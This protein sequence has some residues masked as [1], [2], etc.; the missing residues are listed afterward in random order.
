MKKPR[1]VVARGKGHDPKNQAAPSTAATTNPQEPGLRFHPLANIFPLTEGADFDD[2][3]ADFRAH[4][5]RHAIVLHEGMILDGRNRY[6]ACFAAG[7]S[8]EDMTPEERPGY[9]QKFFG[10]DPVA[11]VISANLHRRHLT[12]EQKREIIAKVI[13]ATPA[14]S[15]RAV[16]K[17]AKA[18]GKTVASVRREMEGRAEVP[19]VEKRIDAKGREQPARKRR[20]VHKLT[21]RDGLPSA[22]EIATADDDKLTEIFS[23][24]SIIERLRE[25]LRAAE[26]KIAG[27]ESENEELRAERDR[28][29]AENEG[30]RR[31]AVPS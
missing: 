20:E 26:I 23:A 17:I 9:F 13:A 2:L 7:M 28:L 22:E 16:G 21:A 12:A 15:D 19:H 27:L 1:A 11:F 4:G 14:K 10:D 24:Q 5:L 30:L 6:R 18:D 8:I 31:A 25:Q 29:R 3:V